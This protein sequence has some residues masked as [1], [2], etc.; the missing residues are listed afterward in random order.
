M[1][2]SELFS[3][4]DACVTEGPDSVVKGLATDSRL[5]GRDFV[6]FGVEGTRL[7]GASYFADAVKN[8]ATCLVSSKP[9]PINGVTRVIVPNVR[10]AVWQ[11]ASAYYGH[12]EKTLKSAGITGTNGKTTSTYLLASVLQA[13]GA[14]AGLLGTISYTVGGKSFPSKLTTPDPIRLYELLSQMVA[15]GDKWVVMEV[16]S[17][18]L[19]QERI[20]GINYDGAIFT[21]LTRDHLDYHKTMENYAAAKAKLFELVKPDGIVAINM[22]DK[23]GPFISSRA[24]GSVI[25]FGLGL[26]GPV[27]LDGVVLDADFTKLTMLY[28]ERRV[29]IHC[30][31]VGRFNAFNVLGV[32]TLAYGFGVSSDA[33]KNG[34][35]NMHRVPGRLERVAPRRPRVYVDYA[36]TD[37]ALS[38]ALRALK[39]LPHN[40][41]H[42]VFGCGGD[43]D[44]GKR[45]MMGAAAE[46]LADKVVITSD[47]PR[48]EDPEAIIAEILTGITDRSRIETV[49]SRADAIMHAVRNAGEDDIVLVA[50]KGHENYQIFSDKTIH[51]DDREV[52]LEAINGRS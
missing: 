11:A 45:P 50:G 28:G 6:F 21:N 1:R 44:R 15:E 33:V 22:T 23:W 10:R 19:E 35:E 18:S 38:N 24:S 37:D 8:G 27:Q 34:I 30:P 40:K 48:S 29:E 26:K 52:A 41:L 5:V 14:N 39:E 2:I 31:L 36:H 42:V 13:S 16:S 49:V 43:R 47:N 46:K 32:A 4:A 9:I 25:P 17:H 7:D 3:H 51:F 20:G 12:P